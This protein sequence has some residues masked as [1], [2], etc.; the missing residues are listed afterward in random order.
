MKKMKFKDFI[1]LIKE[2]KK[3]IEANKKGTAEDRFNTI[4]AN[5]RH[6][7]ILESF[8]DQ[9]AIKKG[10]QKVYESLEALY[11][12]AKKKHPE[13]NVEE[14]IN[15]IRKKYDKNYKLGVLYSSTN[16]SRFPGKEKILEY[17]KAN[18]IKS[19]DDVKDVDKYVAAVEKIGGEDLA[20]KVY[21]DAP[22]S[23]A[24]NLDYVLDGLEEAIN[25]P[26]FAY[27][28]DDEVEFEQHPFDLP[29]EELLDDKNNE[30]IENI[31]EMDIIK[32]NPEN[33][34]LFSDLKI[35]GNITKDIHNKYYNTVMSQNEIGTNEFNRELIKN[36]FYDKLDELTETYH[37]PGDKFGEMVI[38]PGKEEEFKE[39][40]NDTEMHFTS[41]AKEGLKKILNKYIELNLPRGKFEEGTKAY[42][43]KNVYNKAK[44]IRNKLDEI[45]EADN[46]LKEK[47]EQIKT[48]DAANKAKLEEEKKQLDDNKLKLVNDLIV[49][50][51]EYDEHSAKIDELT[52][53]IDEYFP[54]TRGLTTNVDVS[55]TTDMPVKYRKQYI[56]SSLLN[57]VRQLVALIDDFG[58]TID[59]FVDDPSKYINQAIDTKY[60]KGNSAPNGNEAT[61]EEEIDHLIDESY[62]SKTCRDREAVHTG[63][64]RGLELLVAV[65]NENLEKNLESHEKI[66]KKVGNLATIHTNREIVRENGQKTFENIFA[67]RDK[68]VVDLLADPFVDP[69][70]HEKIEASDYDPDRYI[71]MGFLDEDIA[72]GLLTKKLNTIIKAI[73]KKSEPENEA[74]AK[75]VY[76]SSNVIAEKAFE[77]FAETALKY[78]QRNMIDPETV[79]DP[80]LKMM[81]D[82]IKDP[83][84]YLKQNVINY[85]SK[86]KAPKAAKKLAKLS[87]SNPDNKDLYAKAEK[88]YKDLEKAA[89]KREKAFDK[90]AAKKKKAMDKQIKALMKKDNVGSVDLINEEQKKY[91]EFLVDHC[92][93]LRRQYMDG[94]ITEGFFLNRM[95]QIYSGIPLGDLKFDTK[96]LYLT[97]KQFIDEAVLNEFT[98]FDAN[99]Y[100]DPEV[101]KYVKAVKKNTSLDKGAADLNE[102]KDNEEIEYVPTDE[103][104]FKEALDAFNVRLEA[105]K[106]SVIKYQNEQ[107]AEYAALVERIKDSKN[108]FIENEVRQQKKIY[109]DIIVTDGHHTYDEINTIGA[110]DDF[111][112]DKSVGFEDDDELLYSAENENNISKEIIDENEINTNLNRSRI[113]IDLNESQSSNVSE[114]IKDD[115]EKTK[116]LNTSINK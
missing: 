48:A 1:N 81:V 113:S 106:Q 94:K 20:K 90:L 29:D 49:L 80:E 95:E 2:N 71:N 66:L 85:P 7:Y 32:N 82:A 11:K 17:N 100:H 59:K 33:A 83:N 24:I 79:D 86:L 74:M 28:E 102:L 34:E 63:L 30:V 57:G 107:K 45:K 25:D 104:K 6:K 53:L 116:D 77:A 27:K 98:D 97:E 110:K 87:K 37:F 36:T 103:E 18:N 4:L 112:D 70:T 26:N 46:A 5:E 8:I 115:D 64:A 15:N 76:A 41:K 50:K 93:E 92:N 40:E 111:E 19:S 89:L 58:T 43:Y 35:V 52:N 44:D 69:V 10:N 13:I 65:D 23:G 99:P 22:I 31:Q 62:F 73:I 42:G 60:I 75:T 3:I 105:R 14:E 47:E 12:A 67:S 38:K 68:K 72:K 84:K 88:N 39:F 91:N 101:R 21:E 109:N 9:I 108:I 55:R 54:N 51:K 114:F 16:I 56:K 96:E 61:F 78:M